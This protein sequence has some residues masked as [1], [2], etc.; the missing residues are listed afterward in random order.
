[1]I[2]FLKYWKFIGLALIFVAVFGAGYRV[3]SLGCEK[4]KARLFKQEVVET[5]KLEKIEE[6]KAKELEEFKTELARKERELTTRLKNEISNNA[7]YNC[8]LPAGGVRILN[9]A[10][11]A[12]NA[13]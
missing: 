13:G 1:M 10:I 7:N 9:E 6:E 4:E 3:A 8:K 2:F 11:E 12:S 5:E